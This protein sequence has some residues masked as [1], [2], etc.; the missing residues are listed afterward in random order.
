M[1]TK[2]KLHALRAIGVDYV[3]GPGLRNIGVGVIKI[4]SSSLL[5]FFGVV[6]SVPSTISQLS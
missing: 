4:I 5:W 6:K 1:K 2:D 3:S